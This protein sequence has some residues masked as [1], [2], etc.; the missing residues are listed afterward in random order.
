MSWGTSWKVRGNEVWDLTENGL[1]TP[2][3]EEQAEVAGAAAAQLILSGAFGDPGKAFRVTLSGHG[4][5]GHEPAEGWSNDFIQISV[6]QLSEPP[7][8]D[9]A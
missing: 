1:D 6:S 3:H 4:N 9:N 5:S 2:E 7:L 8:G